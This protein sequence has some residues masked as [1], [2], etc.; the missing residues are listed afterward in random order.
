MTGALKRLACWVCEVTF[1]GVTRGSYRR[2]F[3]T[4]AR[5]TWK[6]TQKQVSLSIAWT[7][8]TNKG[9]WKAASRTKKVRW[10]KVQT[11]DG[12]VTIII[13]SGSWQVRGCWGCFLSFLRSTRT[14][15]ERRTNHHR[16]RI[17]SLE[18]HQVFEINFVRG[19]RGRGGRWLDKEHWRSFD[20]G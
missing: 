1:K 13:S 15:W 2:K 6:D 8:E 20:C 12:N 19:R 9:A 3:R 14:F 16:W 7:L 4:K 18:D 5:R 10:R 11:A 17:K